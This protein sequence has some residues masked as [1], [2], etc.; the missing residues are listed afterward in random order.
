[1][2]IFNF[3]SETEKLLI[4]CKLQFLALRSSVASFQI[5]PDREGFCLLKTLA[6]VG[7]IYATDPLLQN[8]TMTVYL[9]YF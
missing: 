7:I 6:T 2:E 3:S 9:R 1:M 5:P 4:Y 8:M